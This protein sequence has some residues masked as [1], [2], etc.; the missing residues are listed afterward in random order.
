MHS[1][2]VSPLAISLPLRPLARLRVVE[3]GMMLTRS[4]F[5]TSLPRL[6]PSDDPITAIA[7]RTLYQCVVEP[8]QRGQQRRLLRAWQCGEDTLDELLL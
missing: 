6:S 7:H 2:N 1:Q 5:S 3:R 4:M 8:S